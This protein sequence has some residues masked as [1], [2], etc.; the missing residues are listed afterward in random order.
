[1]YIQGSLLSAALSD[2]DISITFSSKYNTNIHETD[3][4]GNESKF[5]GVF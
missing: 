3:K 1:M 4:L 2:A 5:L